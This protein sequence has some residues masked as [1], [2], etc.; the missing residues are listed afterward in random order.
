MPE[1]RAEAKNERERRKQKTNI[2]LGNNGK[3][4]PVK[5][6]MCKAT[7]SLHIP[8]NA[9]HRSNQKEWKEG[10]DEESEEEGGRDGACIL[11]SRGGR[12]Q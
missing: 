2:A 4:Q 10:E 12:N 8:K 11:A 7:H 6:R 1:N 5:Q 3:Q 9:P